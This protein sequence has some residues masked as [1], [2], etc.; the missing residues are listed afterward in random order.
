VA[1]GRAGYGPAGAF[2][3]FAL[4]YEGRLLR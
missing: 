4:R 1:G 2:R 3:E